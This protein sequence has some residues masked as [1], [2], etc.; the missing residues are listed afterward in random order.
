RGN[1]GLRILARVRGTMDVAQ[2]DLSNVAGRLAEAYPESN[3]GLT[4]RVIPLVE[5]ITGAVRPPLAALAAA[6]GLFL[7]IACATVASLVL[8]RDASRRREF[9]TRAA[10]GA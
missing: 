7:L 5:S 8:A 10:L 9:A 3:R 2:S 4:A 6:G 1:R